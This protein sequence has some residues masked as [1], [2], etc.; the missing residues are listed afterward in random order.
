MRRTWVA[1]LVMALAST[2]STAAADERIIGGEQIGIDE[3]PW[4]VSLQD[5]SGHRCGAVIVA[6]DTLLTAAHCTADVSPWELSVRAGTDDLGRGGDVRRVSTVVQHPDYDPGT[7]DYDISVLRLRTPLILGPEI[8]PIA[9]ADTEPHAGEWAWVVG[10]GAVVEYGQIVDHLRAVS[11]PIVT[12]TACKDSYG[13]T[14]ITARMLCAG[15][16]EGGR[17]ACQGDSGGP[18]T[19]ADREVVGLVSWGHGCGRARYYGIYT[20]LADP[21]L[22]PWIHH[23]AGV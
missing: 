10:W 20:N 19:I 3:A 2:G 18:L 5:T 1:L 4:V 17:D 12:E 13:A 7:S 15:L 6:N 16:P 21:T 9:V 22:R 8:T 23:N 14:A 11:V